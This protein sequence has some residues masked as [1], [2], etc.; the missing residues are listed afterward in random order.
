ME[1]EIQPHRDPVADRLRRVQEWPRQD[2]GPQYVSS[3][4]ANPAVEQ[5]DVERGEGK[6]AR[7]VGN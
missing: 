1:R 7:V 6:L 5:I 2:H 3:P 4:R